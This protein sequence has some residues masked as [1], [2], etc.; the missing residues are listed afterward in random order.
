MLETTGA[1][2]VQVKASEEDTILCFESLFNSLVQML[3]SFN[4]LLI[5]RVQSVSSGNILPECFF[6]AHCMCMNFFGMIVV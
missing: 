1:I 2:N 4:S 6:P 3:T 5:K